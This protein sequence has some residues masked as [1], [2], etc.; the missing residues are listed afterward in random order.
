VNLL[1]F[2]LGMDADHSV[3]GHTTAWTNEL[4]RRC[5]HVSVITMFAGRLEVD[6]NVTVHSLGKE[7]GRSEPRRLVEFYRLVRLV[8]DER[9]ID[10]C[11]AHMAPLFTVL[12]AP[13]AR[14]HGIP[15]LLWYAHR[16][17]TPTLRIAH[18]LADRCVTANS[19]SF[20]LPSDKLFVVGHGID[21][22][23]FRP[24]RE[25]AAAY[26]TTAVSVGRITRIKGLQEMIEAV[27]ILERE[28]GL[29]LR[30]E[31]VGGPSTST[32]HEYLATLERS[33][34]SLG[35]QHLV[36]FR[37]PVPF[38]EIAPSYHRGVLFLNL[39]DTALDKA[40]LES[41]AS[42]CIPV[43]RNPAFQALAHAQGLDW[44]VPAPG[45]HGL[46]DCIGSALQRGRADRPALVARLRSIVTEEHSLSRLSDRIIA[47]L[48]ELA[49]GSRRGTSDATMRH[50]N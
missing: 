22:E 4:A 23:K 34:A 20:R 30:L 28:R 5:D 32:D 1:V 27:A 13:V 37:G 26:E 8:L 31:L 12:F 24:P 43:S 2:N 49:P 19:A 29:S 47:H 14:R 17:V 36:S 44:L 11:F 15:V 50:A 16:S 45:P 7:L 33:V 39:S 3:L 18:A 10:A 9:H 42:G 41:M 6:D 40:I 35:M 38:Y 48:S 46:A 21:T 25:T